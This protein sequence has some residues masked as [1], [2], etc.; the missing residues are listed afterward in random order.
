MDFFYVWH[1]R[2]LY[3]LS[4]E[5]D[6]AF[7]KPLSPKWD[8]ERNDGELI[9]DS[10]RFGGDKQKSKANYEDGM[11]RVFQACY[12]S[13][14]P[15]GRLV[16]VFAHKHPD[17]W[18]TLVSALIRAGFVVDGS[19]PIQTEMSNRT[20]ALSS[21]AL[22]SSVWL[23]CKKR[24]ENARPGWDNLVLEEMQ[25]NIIQ[26]LRNFWD[27]GIRGPDFVWA[28]TGPALEAYSKH[29]IVR[30]ANE[31]GKT[32]SVTEF[33]G[34]VRRMV[35][36]FVVGRVLTR[37]GGTDM[38]SGL[39]DVT[40][41]YLLHRYNFGL[42]STPIG[43]CILYAVSCNLSDSL[44]LGKCDL[45]VGTGGQNKDEDDEGED[46]EEEEGT[47][48]TVKL[49]PWSQ[50]KYAGIE[51]AGLTSPLIDKVHRLM[52]LW[53]AGDV[54]KVDEYLDM[55]GLGYNT[56]FGQLL[57]ALIELAP[58]QSDERALLEK[59][60]NHVAERSGLQTN[61]LRWTD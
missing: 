14:K 49:K 28:A 55:H 59:I 42:E 44:L 24:P 13:L 9:D 47:S 54:L 17:A 7:Q 46:D 48:S 27:A 2:S 20:R 61:R 34:H 11:F 4:P 3:G 58:A 8:H 29:S 31:Q 26:C 35:A 21:A 18:E 23:V 43:P 40:T 16:L 10:S 36:D 12:S 57:Q 56:L 45:L 6:A 51:S 50:R 53:R 60:S 22:A 38:V 15:D 25:K 37:N 32:L 1:R 5:L 19:W 33:L 52:H 41:Y 39:D 30:K